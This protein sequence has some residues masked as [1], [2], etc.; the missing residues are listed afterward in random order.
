[1]YSWFDK[2]FHSL[3]FIQNH[4]P[5]TVLT[6]SFPFALSDFAK[7]KLYRRVYQGF[8]LIE[9]LIYLLLSS[10][11][12]L[13]LFQFTTNSYQQYKKINLNNSKLIQALLSLDLIT[14]DIQKSCRDIKNWKKINNS[15]IIFAVKSNTDIGWYFKDN[16][17]YRIEGEYDQNKDHWKNKIESLCASNLSNFHFLIYKEN[18]IKLIH[19]NI[20]VVIGTKERQFTKSVTPCNR[21]IGLI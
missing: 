20:A 6:I 2:F 10:I 7:A 17:L 14:N 11:F 3:K 8:L 9:V 1:M 18:E 16:K 12:F 21:L 4:S 19:I 15:E 13:F 5:R